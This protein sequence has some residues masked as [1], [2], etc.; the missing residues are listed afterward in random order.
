MTAFTDAYRAEAERLF[1][2]M[3]IT[4]APHIERAAKRILKIKP[5]LLAVSA[6]TGVPWPW[7]GAILE[8][9][10]SCR[11]DRHMHNGDPLTA[12][13]THVPKGRLP[14]PASPP[15][16]FND[17]AYD[18]LCTLKGL[19]RISDWSIGRQ[20]YEAERYNGFGYRRRSLRSPYLWGSTNHQ[21]LGK[22]VAD[23]VFDRTAM[24][25]Q[26]GVMPLIKR[27]MEMDAVSG[28]PTPALPMPRDLKAAAIDA[29][30][31]AKAAVQ[32]ATA[33]GVGSVG[34]SGVEIASQTTDW[35]TLVLVLAALALIGLAVWLIRRADIHNR[36]AEALRQ[37]ASDAGGW[38]TARAMLPAVSHEAGSWT[39]STD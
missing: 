18:A 13:T 32:G 9:E 1:A 11:I 3:I 23:G 25:R 21:Q 17:S 24:D 6:R 8:R 39:Q 31:R 37:A 4:D 19:H 35:L 22:Y 14:A 5:T 26:P 7:L 10:S 2:S 36:A 16:A 29:E 33:S 28:A 27:V 34:A 38:A 20:A 15:F 12:R 30:Q